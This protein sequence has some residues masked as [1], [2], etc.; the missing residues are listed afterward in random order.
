MTD[1]AFEALVSRLEQEARRS[2]TRYQWK[3]VGLALLGNAYLASIVLVLVGMVLAVIASIAVLK[4]MAIK[5]VLVLGVVVAL[6]LKSLWVRLEPPRGTPLSRQDSPEFFASID[7]LRR[8]MRAP[9]FH[10]VLLTDE[11]NASVMQMPRLGALGWSHN[12]LL[13]GLPLL[14]AMKVQQFEAV[15]AHELAHLAHGHG[16]LANWVYSQR[17]RWS[18]LMG[19][20]DQRKSRA[21]WLFAPFLKRFAPYFNAYSFPLAR[22][23]EYM[24]DAAAARVTSSSAIADALTS[25][26]VVGSYLSERYWRDIVRHADEQPMPAF[27]PHAA[28]GATLV[29]DLDPGTIKSYMERALAARTGT[30]DTHPSLHDRLLSLGDKARLHLPKEGHAADRLLG[31]ALPELTQAFDLRWRESIAT[32]WNER[33]NAV[34]AGRDCLADLDRRVNEGEELTRREAF[35]RAQLTGDIAHDNDA[36]IDQLRVLVA[37]DD[38]DVTACYALAARLMARNDDEGLQHMEQAILLDEF[39]IPHAL[40]QMRD[41]HHRHGR[42][43]PARACHERLVQRLE[44]EGRAH[45]ERSRF[46]PTDTLEEHDLPAEAVQSLR[47]QLEGIEGLRCAY[48]ARKRV[49]HLPH[50]HCYVLAFK[51]GPWWKGR[52]GHRQRLDAALEAIQARL[53][54]PGETILLCIDGEFAR[55]R[56][57]LKQL[58]NARLR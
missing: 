43:A 22:A 4:A 42:E 41:Y 3:V 56:G 6:V 57:A 13:V 35:E 10:R 49:E 23:N 2:P 51:L 38:D 32:A 12:Y 16:R 48:I 28:M 45:Q 8:A 19:E 31:R 27:A 52:V 9:R 29:Q 7:R 39:A 11:F 26:A 40:E 46:L 34:K 50:R 47:Q 25:V 18:R 36:A 33:F 55:L 5:L 17:Q 54:L 21:S 24:A 1:E 30:A 37:T 15:V 58:S 20:M 53:S 44:I 14:K